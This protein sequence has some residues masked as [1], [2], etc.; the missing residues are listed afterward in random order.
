MR[1]VNCKECKNDFEHHGSRGPAAEFCRPCK[2]KR[3]QAKNYYLP[4]LPS[5]PSNDEGS[6]GEL[7]HE[8]A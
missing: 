2:H 6:A 5:T 4:A 3:R 1:L 8:Q 7:P